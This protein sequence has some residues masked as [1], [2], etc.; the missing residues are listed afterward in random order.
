M[1]KDIT[2]Q[3]IDAFDTLL[4][5]LGD[6]FPDLEYVDGM[7]CAMNFFPELISV[8]TILYEIVGDDFEF[9]NEKQANEF[10][11]LLF[12]Y[13]NAVLNELANPSRTLADPYSP[14]CLKKNEED[15]IDAM[16]WANGF[17]HGM[18]A[19]PESWHPITKEEHTLQ[20]LAPVIALA[21]QNHPVPELRATKIAKKDHEKFIGGMLHNVRISFDY[22]KGNAIRTKTG[23][24]SPITPMKPN[25]N[26]I[27]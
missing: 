21:G 19:S 7:L 24:N 1:I 5:N 22:L 4:H 3:D 2:E 20:L 16:D 8:D 15:H 26:L 17:I 27:H 11:G 18:S 9:Q 13:N 14:F 10:M 6:D 12:T 23:F 25:P